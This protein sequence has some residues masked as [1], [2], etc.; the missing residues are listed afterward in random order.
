MIIVSAP[1]CARGFLAHLRCLRKAPVVTVNDYSLRILHPRIS[2]EGFRS[3]NNKYTAELE[4]GFYWKQDIGGPRWYKIC[5][6]R[7]MPD[8]SNDKPFLRNPDEPEHETLL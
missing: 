3:M 2:G 8:F 7:S 5:S 6:A 4:N 1:F